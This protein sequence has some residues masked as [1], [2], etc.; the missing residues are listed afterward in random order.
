MQL[1]WQHGLRAVYHKKWCE[2][3]QS[4]RCYLQ[5]LKYRGD[6]SGPLPGS[7]A[8]SSM[9]VLALLGEDAGL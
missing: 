8:E 1:G 9:H 5:A 2:V 3:S 7:G 4:V 6:L